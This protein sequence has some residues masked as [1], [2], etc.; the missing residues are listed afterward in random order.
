MSKK[1]NVKDAI[2]A[3]IDV[4]TLENEAA[5]IPKI[6]LIAATLVKLLRESIGNKLSV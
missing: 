2:N 3:V 1:S 6:K 5:V 4:S